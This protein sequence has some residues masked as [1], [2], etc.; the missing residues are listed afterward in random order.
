MRG[1]D[2][3]DQLLHIFILGGTGHNIGPKLVEIGR[4]ALKEKAGL[5]SARCGNNFRSAR[6]RSSWCAVAVV[7]GYSALSWATKGALERRW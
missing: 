4:N 5:I 1:E 3:S 2:G 7:V 6:T